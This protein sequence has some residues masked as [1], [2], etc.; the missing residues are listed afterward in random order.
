VHGALKKLTNLL[1]FDVRIAAGLELLVDAVAP[2][3]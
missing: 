1:I 3:L 2:L